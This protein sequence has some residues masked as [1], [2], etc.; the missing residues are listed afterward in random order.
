MQPLTIDLQGV[1][2]GLLQPIDNP[3]LTSVV[4]EVI[5]QTHPKVDSAGFD[6]RL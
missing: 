4:E 1:T 3:A 2:I 5:D 6:N